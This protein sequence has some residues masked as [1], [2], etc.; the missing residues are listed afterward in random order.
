MPWHIDNFHFWKRN[1][2]TSEHIIRFIVFQEDW[3]HGQIIQAGSSIISHWQAGDAVTWH[4]TRWHLSTNAGVENKWTTAV[5][6]ILLEEFEVDQL[7]F[8]SHLD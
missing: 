5:T 2:P 3:K 7:I 8:N 1:Y 4:P 6:G